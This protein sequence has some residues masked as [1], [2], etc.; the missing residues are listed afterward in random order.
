MNIKKNLQL[1][2]KKLTDKKNLISKK[3]KKRNNVN[4][5][6]IKNILDIL[7]LYGI[8]PVFYILYINAK[9]NI[10][11][12]M[13]IYFTLITSFANIFLLTIVLTLAELFFS[14]EDDVTIYS[15]AIVQNLYIAFIYEDQLLPDLKN[16]GG[17]NV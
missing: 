8:L 5:Q 15:I 17:G 7:L 3:L 16:N 10:N 4:N 1:L 11:L 2:K 14:V 9:N 12:I 6:S 13:N